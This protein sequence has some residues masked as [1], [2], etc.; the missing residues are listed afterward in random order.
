MLVG[1]AE[2]PCLFSSMFVLGCG[3]SSGGGEGPGFLT[4]VEELDAA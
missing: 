2:R 4:H 1:K 3:V